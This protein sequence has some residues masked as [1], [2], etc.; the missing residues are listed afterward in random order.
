MQKKLK[1]VIHSIYAFRGKNPDLRIQY[2]VIKEYGKGT[3]KS[4]HVYCGWSDTDG[5]PCKDVKHGVLNSRRQY[6]DFD[7]WFDQHAPMW[8]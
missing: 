5:G 2:T 1:D 3:S 8:R 6:A 4:W 7:V